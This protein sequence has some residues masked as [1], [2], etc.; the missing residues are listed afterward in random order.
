M[1][2]S[3]R[4]LGGRRSEKGEFPFHAAVYI[5]SLFNCGGS[6]ISDKIVLTAAHCMVDVI[7]VLEKEVFRVIL[8]LTDLRSLTGVEAIRKVIELVCYKM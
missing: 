2:S 3:H 6:L 1:P 8:G 5:N 7:T 4:I